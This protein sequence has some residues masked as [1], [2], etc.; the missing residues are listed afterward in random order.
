MI[1]FLSMRKSNRDLNDETHH[2]CQVLCAA[3]ILS[4]LTCNNQRNK[5]KVV[6]LQGVE[7]LLEVCLRFATKEE[8]TEVSG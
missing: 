2:S 7:L 4:N 1:G 6:H 3:G 5:M 8:I